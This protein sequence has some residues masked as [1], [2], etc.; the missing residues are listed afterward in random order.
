[1]AIEI[2]KATRERLI[3]S[4]QRYFAEHLE[5]DIGHLKASLLF[6]F[7]LKEIG[8]SVHN[9]AVGDAQTA[10]QQ[11]VSEINGMCF[12]REFGFWKR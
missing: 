7:A 12:E 3:A 1:V 11:M 4:I 10:I 5:Q 6:D 8:P 9:L 2:D